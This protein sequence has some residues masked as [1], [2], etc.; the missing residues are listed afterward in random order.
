MAKFEPI[1]V[2]ALTIIVSCFILVYFGINSIVS[3]VLIMVCAYYFGK[4][5]S[6]VVHLTKSNE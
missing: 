6:G 3:G 5:S 1:D 4:R 2:I